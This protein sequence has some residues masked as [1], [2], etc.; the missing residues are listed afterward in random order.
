[1]GEV[2]NK[3]D[4]KSAII[5][6]V[7]TVLVFV[8]FGAKT[9][10]DNLGD[11]TVSSITVVDEDGK[12][13][14]VLGYSEFGGFLGIYSKSAPDKIVLL[15]A[16]PGGGGGLIL[17]NEQEKPVIS[18][19]SKEGGRGDFSLYDDEESR[20][21]VLTT[22]EYGGI[23]AIYNSHKNLTSGLSID[24]NEDGFIFLNDRYG[25]LGWSMTG[26]K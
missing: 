9:K 16:T 19:G 2:M 12:D 4:V 21:V 3:I 17:F 25:D 1:M 15:S 6:I 8:L 14:G 26:K 18:L 22:V 5:G 24:E 10:S 7:G 23:L 11:I 13:M 20:V